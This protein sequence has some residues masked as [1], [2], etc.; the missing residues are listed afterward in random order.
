MTESTSSTGSKHSLLPTHIAIVPD[1]N[2]RWAKKRGLPRLEGHREGMDNMYRMVEYL[3]EY[4]IPYITLYG[5]STENWKRPEEEVYGLF[6]LL[7]DF[8]ERIIPDIHRRGIK[9]RH[10]GRLD[11]L[12]DDLQS[13][14][15]EAVETTR[16]NTAIT[17]NIAFNYGGRAEIVD[18]V[19]H[20]INDGIPSQDISEDLM[21]NYLYTA[22]TPSVDLLIRTGNEVRLSNFL[23]WQTSYSEI[24]FSRVLWPDFGKKD[25]DKSLDFY[26]RRKR[27]FGG[28]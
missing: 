2:G 23:I 26:R 7:T 27:R 28:L 4:A 20:I 18:A 9:L 24:Y 3:S 25:I 10:I 14:I 17:L 19:R 6:E 22:G 15:S 11:E 16:N 13:S 1:G 8:I 5:F 21:E 12:P